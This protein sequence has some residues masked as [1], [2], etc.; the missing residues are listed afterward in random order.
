M[1][2]GNLDYDAIIIGGGPGGATA[3]LVLARLGHR[4]CIFE[5][6]VHP[7]FHIG[8]S[9]LPRNMAM[10]RELGLEEQMRHVPHVPKYGA[11][12]AMGDDFNTMQFLF[13]DGLLAG[14][15]VFNIER[16]AFD[17]MLL[18]QARDAGAVV[19]EATA[20]KSIDRLE[21]GHVAVTTEEGRQSVT[22]RVLL[23]AS[24]HGTVVGRHLKQRRNFDDP[25]LQ[26]VAYFEHFDDVERLPGEAS[27]HPSIVMAEEGWFWLIGLTDRKTSV[28][29]VTRPSFVR[30][31]GVAP[32]DMLQWA[33]AR[34]PVVRHR[35]RAAT[36]PQTNLVLADFSYTCSPQAGPGYFLIGDAGCFLDPIFSTGVTLAMVGGNEAA[37]QVDQ[38]LRGVRS[39][40]SAQ[41]R[42][43][44]FVE[45][46]TAIFWRLIRKYYRHSFR[47]LFMHGRGPHNVHGAI[48]SVLAGQVFPRPPWALRW[49]MR[50]FELCVWLQ[51]YIPL[52]PRRR[53]FRLLDEQPLK[54]PAARETATTAASHA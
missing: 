49:R 17:K 26:K 54:L 34:C 47:E 4:V 19:H 8:E 42:Y 45:G 52:V 2:A 51:Q 21:D 44:H 32:Y 16:A 48:I 27:G 20:V 10:L 25:Q 18:D 36:G 39:P 50:L 53:R 11:E 46:S 6:D 30:D 38:M 23:D 15:R 33:V 40:R 13:A 41:R 43:I 7:R 22:A 35:M 14:E 3:A 1:S 9:I 29:F 31:L 37:R 28:G 12:F 24:G 5:K